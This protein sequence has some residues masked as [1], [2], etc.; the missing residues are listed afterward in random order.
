[1]TESEAHSANS[2]AARWHAVLAQN[3]IVHK[4]HLDLIASLTSPFS[5]AQIELLEASTDRFRRLPP[6]IQ[7]LVEDWAQSRKP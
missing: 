2:Y 7:Q 1:M 6:Q 3:S 4:E 5:T